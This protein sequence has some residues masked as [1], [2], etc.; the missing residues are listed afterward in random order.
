MAWDDDKADGDSLTSDEWDNHVADQKTRAKNVVQGSEPATS[1]P[2]GTLWSRRSVRYDSE[3]PNSPTT[4]SDW[5]NVDFALNQSKGEMYYEVN[6]NDEVVAVDLESGTENWR[7][8]VGFGA[9]NLYYDGVNDRVFCVGGSGANVAVLNASDASEVWNK[10]VGSDSIS[11]SAYDSNN[12]NIVVVVQ[13]NNIQSFNASDGTQNWSYSQGTK[14]SI[15]HVTA[16]DYIY[17]VQDDYNGQMLTLN[18]VDG[19]EVLSSSGVH[20]RAAQDVI[21]GEGDYAYFTN[22]RG[23]VKKVDVTTHTI[24]WQHSH[25]TGDAIKD[26]D[27]YEPHDAVYSSGGYQTD[28]QTVAASGDGGYLMD[29]HTLHANRNYSVEYD[30]TND[31]VVSADLDDKFIWVPVTPTA[32]THRLI[33]TDWLVEE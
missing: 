2:D 12:D 25:H 18:A 17:A 15:G 3:S 16:N 9:E 8:T 29:T 6:N 31:R 14:Y 5:T 13:Y 22:D 20:P 4:F 28:Y 21:G 24:I 11:G 19:S 33:G 10:S 32:E 7:T 1:N 26:I 30:G 27:Y 23:E